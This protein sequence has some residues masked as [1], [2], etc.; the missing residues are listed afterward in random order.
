MLRQGGCGAGGGFC[1]PR[2]LIISLSIMTELKRKGRI[3]GVAVTICF[4]AVIA[5]AA[6][7]GYRKPMGNWD[8]LGYAGVAFSADS[9]EYDSIHHRTYSTAKVALRELF[10]S[11]ASPPDYGYAD[12]MRNNAAHFTEQLPFYSNRLGY[13]LLLR[14]LRKFGLDFFTGMRLVSAASFFLLGPVTLLWM[15]RLKVPVGFAAPVST[16]MLLSPHMLGLCRLG[17]PD[18]ISTLCVTTGLY[19]VSETNVQGLGIGLSLGSL[20]LRTDSIVL[21]LFILGY[22]ACT[23]TPAGKLPARVAVGTGAA[24]VGLVLAINRLSGTYGLATLFHHTFVTL[25]KT[26]GETKVAMTPALY[27]SGIRRLFGELLGRQFFLLSM[28]IGCLALASSFTPRNKNM[29]LALFGAVLARL[30]VFPCPEDRFFATAGIVFVVVASANVTTSP[31][32]TN[33]PHV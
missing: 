19:L 4:L 8:M 30:I 10:D 11:P 31:A 3:S 16:L 33:S 5:C 29:C 20:L 1:S 26:P 23:R 15:T 18:A 21:F 28:L 12:D 32:F 2:A 25:M 9:S 6:V 13:I 27:L 7:L 17:T 14:F 24:A 22:L